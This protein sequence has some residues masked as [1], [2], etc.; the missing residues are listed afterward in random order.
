[1]QPALHL[2]DTHVHFDAFRESGDLAAV[3]ERARAAGVRRFVAIGGAPAGNAFAAECAAQRP[4]EIVFA[5]GYDRYLA[6]EPCDDTALSALLDQPGAAAVGEIGLDYHYG[7]ETK[8][9]Q[10]ELF[11]RM[12]ALARTRRLPVVVHSR[13]AEDDTIAMLKEHAAAWLGD[14]G[15]LG[16]LHCFTGGPEFVERVL[17]AG[18]LVSF[19]GILSFRNAD[20]IRAAAKLVP[21]DRLLI[22]TDSPYLAPVPHRGKHNEPAFVADVARALAAAREEAVEAVAR[23]TTANAERLFNIKGD[24]Q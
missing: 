12:L 3:V 11:A 22:E 15:R 8:P 21:A 6:G 7:P 18:L 20:S 9:A 5:A 2:V 1:M 16:V 13:E 4:A 17:T 23:Q 14:P 19:S 10:R 24:M